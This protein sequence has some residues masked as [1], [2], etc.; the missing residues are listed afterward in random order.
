MELTSLLAFATLT[1]VTTPLLW[2]QPDGVISLQ[3]K[4]VQPKFSPGTRKVRT[5]GPVAFD[6]DGG[7]SGILFGDVSALSL[8]RSMTISTWINPRSYVN[9]GPGAQLLFRGD[10]RNG[11]DPYTFCVHA[12]GTVR[13]GVS[14][15]DGRA[16]SVGAELA[17]NRWTHILTSF[18]SE[19][20]RLTMYINGVLSAFCTTSVV[21]FATLDRNWSPGVSVGNVQNNGGPHN[22]PFNGQ[23]ADLRL[24][25]AVLTPD[26]L[27]IGPGNW[28]DPPLAQTAKI[29]SKM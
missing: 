10:D 29:G 24:Y 14:A 3:G 15:D 22:Q 26:D 11:L 6:F 2:L 7:R 16:M 20:G 9:D 4:P 18:D 23:L 17:L 25:G 27:D 1:Q 13:F 12:D 5:S 19:S 28:F 8:T 21:P